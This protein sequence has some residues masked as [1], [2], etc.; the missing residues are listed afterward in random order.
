MTSVMG[1]SHRNIA[2]RFKLSIG[3]ISRHR[4][5]HIGTDLRDVREAMERQRIL[6]ALDEKKTDILK[7]LSEDEL[8]ERLANL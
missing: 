2:K 3:S 1:G 8:K 6:E 7:S 5:A 4:E